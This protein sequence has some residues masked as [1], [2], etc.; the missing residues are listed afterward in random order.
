MFEEIDEDYIVIEPK[1]IDF[2][3]FTDAIKRLIAS[4]DTRY[5]LLLKNL[6]NRADPSSLNYFK[7]CFYT[8]E[9]VIIKSGRLFD[10]P[11]GFVAWCQAR[12]FNFPQATVGSWLLNSPIAHEFLACLSQL[13]LPVYLNFSLAL[14]QVKDKRS[15]VFALSAEVVSAN[16]LLVWLQALH[17]ADRVTEAFALLSRFNTISDSFAHCLA[18]TVRGNFLTFLMVVL[19]SGHLPQVVALLGLSDCRDVSIATLLLAPGSLLQRHGVSSLDQCLTLLHQFDGSGC[20][21]SLEQQVFLLL[22]ADSEEV[23]AMAQR[24]A[25]KVQ[26]AMQAQ[27]YFKKHACMYYDSGQL[28]KI[29]DAEQMQSSLYILAAAFEYINTKAPWCLFGQDTDSV[30]ADQLVVDTLCA[31]YEPSSWNHL[32]L[33]VQ[34]FTE[35]QK[36]LLPTLSFLTKSEER[37]FIVI[38]EKWWVCYVNDY[39][40]YQ[41]NYRVDC[42]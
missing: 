9:S 29:I 42:F 1:I 10:D 18:S 2:Q 22:R 39:N 8:S 4:I 7:R 34:N 6:V 26:V 36:G 15:P 14:L 12:T 27:A 25:Y 3:P 40:A 31:N 37:P 17:R 33:K 41:K 23:E 20:E 19:H 38:L 32:L 5:P 35:S 28:V 21:T 30:I 16:A 11:L 13:T 24:L